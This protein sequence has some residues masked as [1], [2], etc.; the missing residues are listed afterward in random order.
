MR[1]KAG[2]L[3][4]TILKRGFAPDPNEKI[5]KQVLGRIAPDV[6][7]GGLAAAQ[8]PGDAGDKLIAGATQAIGGG[9]GG[10]LVTGA[11]G[12]RLGM[13][14]EFAGGYGG[15]MLGFGIG[16]NLMRAKDKL[17]GGEGMTPYERMSAEQQAQFAEQ[18]RQQILTQYGLIPGTREQYAQMSGVDGL[19]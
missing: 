15:D 12:G 13:L 3:L 10:G 4:A 18:L 16:E 2:Q 6:F 11:T 14:G 8:T 9:L 17:T 7:F 19:S 1:R 5:T